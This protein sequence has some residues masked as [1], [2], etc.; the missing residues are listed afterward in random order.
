[1]DRKFQMVRVEAGDYLLVSNDTKTLWRIKR[2]MEID[3][4]D[5]DVPMW[6]VWRWH[7]PFSPE[8][9]YEVEPDEWGSWSYVSGSFYRRA[10]AIDDALSA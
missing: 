1:M 10:D 8:L 4:K 9:A 5:R 7:R 2:V 3:E 6:E